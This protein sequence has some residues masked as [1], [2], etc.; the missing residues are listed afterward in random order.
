MLYIL[1]AKLPTWSAGK[2]QHPSLLTLWLL[3]ASLSINLCHH[4]HSFY[5]LMCGGK[6]IANSE[7]EVICVLKN[8]IDILVAVDLWKAEDDSLE[9]SE[10][11]SELTAHLQA[12]PQIS[13]W[14]HT[15][16]R[17]SFH[18]ITHTKTYTRVSLLFISEKIIL[19]EELRVVSKCRL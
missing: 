8:D 15:V 3:Y 6:D 17:K 2:K 12:T 5:E 11:H 1:W 16:E 14:K 9:W 18:V 10:L 7:Q 13:T 19:P 4:A